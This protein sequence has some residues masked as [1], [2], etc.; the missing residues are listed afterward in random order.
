MTA[1]DRYQAICHPLANCSWTARRAKQMITGA[2]TI[3]LLCCTPQLFIFSY[4]QVPWT[5]PVSVEASALSDSVASISKLDLT[6][7]TPAPPEYFECWG[8]FIQPWGE[9]I[10]VL[11]YGVSVFF[12]PLSVLTFTYINI[13]K[14]IWI[15]AKRNR[16]AQA[17]LGQR[18]IKSEQIVSGSCSTATSNQTI[19]NAVSKRLRCASTRFSSTNSDVLPKSSESWLSIGSDRSQWRTW[20]CC[21]NS[22]VKL[23]KHNQLPVKSK[24]A[25]QLKGPP[26]SEQEDLSYENGRRTQ[27][28][29][30]EPSHSNRRM[31][32]TPSL[33]SL[34]DETSATN[35]C[36]SAKA[37][38]SASQIP[39]T[40]HHSIANDTKA[41]ESLRDPPSAT[42]A[43]TT[44][45]AATTTTTLN[46]STTITVTPRSHA[47]PTKLSKAKIK[48]IKIT[49]VVIICYIS[50]S[51]PFVLV[52]L[53]AHWWPGAQTSTLWTGKF[54]CNAN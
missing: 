25:D 34:S 39:P 31:P 7:S 30:V 41:G 38:C 4:M 42:V 6:A 23:S 53:W 54:V 18:P 20:L 22:N 13:T 19:S 37:A 1:I 16:Q 49:V 12:I 45:Y 50:C 44:S 27:T 2:W 24:I 35:R 3:A 5:P 15:N 26:Q 33:S 14:V 11:W 8:T 29:Q 51:L 36:D 28:E 43:T 17:N 10:Y 47:D 48:T 21:A 40:D 9:K 46:S 32:L 52:Q